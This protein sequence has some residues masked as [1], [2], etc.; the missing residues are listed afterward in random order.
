MIALTEQPKSFVRRILVVD[1]EPLI[2]TF[3][4]RALLGAGYEVVEAGS[5]ELA[6]EIFAAQRQNFSMLVSDIG[7][8]GASGFELS[9][10][11][12]CL[13]RNL[14]VLLMSA[15]PRRELVG[16]A[17]IAADTFILQKPF[18][19]SDLLGRVNVAHSVSGLRPRL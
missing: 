16:R 15:S 4:A 5:A 9:K 3:V 11:I 8:P 7:L 19:V 12:A 18:L 13:R 17:T 1:D 14:P 10:Q 2:R 6:L